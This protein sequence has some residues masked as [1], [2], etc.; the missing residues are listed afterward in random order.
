MKKQISPL[1]EEMK[2]LFLRD[3]A[4]W[5]D[6]GI[7]RE[8]GKL[9]ERTENGEFEEYENYETA[10]DYPLFRAKYAAHA[11]L[12]LLNALV[13]EQLRNVVAAGTE[14]TYDPNKPM[15]PSE[16]IAHLSFRKIQKHIEDRYRI[17]LVDIE[18]WDHYLK[19]RKI[20]N[21]L[22]HSAGERRLRELFEEGSSWESLHY[23]PELEDAMESVDICL[24]FVRSLFRIVCSYEKTS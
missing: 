5:I 21:T 13:D 23:E 24:R 19:I 20:V 1:I 12:H 11:V 16:K 3:F 7:G 9:Q 15:L 2:F 14:Y 17:S 6:E 22:K 18:G 8:W 10:M 4:S